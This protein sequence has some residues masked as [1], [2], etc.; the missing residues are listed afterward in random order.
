VR[1]INAAGVVLHDVPME[2]GTGSTFTHLR[3][4]WTLWR[5]MRPGKVD[6]VHIEIGAHSLKAST[7]WFADSAKK[8]AFVQSNRA[9][10]MG[11]NW[12][13]IAS[14]RMTSKKLVSNRYVS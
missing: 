1:L 14:I 11:P 8:A 9:S 4:A 2:L 10:G 3:S 5:L 12:R 7:L 13:P 6:V